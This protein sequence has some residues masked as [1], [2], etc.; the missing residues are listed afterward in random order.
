MLWVELNNE[1]IVVGL[2]LS[3]WLYKMVHEVAEGNATWF[4]S[5]FGLHNGG[6][7]IRKELDDIHASLQDCE[8]LWGKKKWDNGF[9][10]KICNDTK[11]ILRIQEIYPLV[12][13][14][15]KITNNFISLSFV[16]GILVE[17][18]KWKV[19]WARF[20]KKFLLWGQKGISLNLFHNL[21]TKRGLF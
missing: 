7:D 3:V 18:N 15:P 9:R 14:K 4:E 5:S 8:L 10:Y 11:L 21:G 6:L 2:I 13:Q 16:H 17:K 19:N 12:H 1:G 20:E